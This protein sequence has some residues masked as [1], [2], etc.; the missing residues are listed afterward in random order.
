MLTEYSDELE[1]NMQSLYNNGSDIFT[2][3][4]TFLHCDS[5]IVT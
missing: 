3:V 4:V 1:K 5:S 2:P